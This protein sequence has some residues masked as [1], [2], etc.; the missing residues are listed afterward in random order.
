M[1]HRTLYLVFFF[2]CFS[3]ITL[4]AQDNDGD[5]ILDN[6]DLDD[7][8]DGILD[9]NDCQIAIPNFSFE[10]PGFTPPY[11]AADDWTIVGGNGTGLHNIEASN[12]PAADEGNYFF[13]MNTNPGVV[14]QATTSNL[15]GIYSEGGYILTV[16]IGDGIGATVFRNDAESI[17]ELGYYDN[18]GIFIT[19]NSRTIDGATETPAG[20]WTDFE[21][22]VNINAGDLALGQGIFI[23]ITHTGATGAQAGNYDNIRLE[24]DSDGDG[25]SNCFE[26]DS[27]GDGINDVLEAGHTDADNNGILDG[28]LNPLDGTITGIDGY[29]GN[30]D[31]V[32]DDNKDGSLILDN[33]GDAYLD[34]D[35][36]DDDNDGI[37]DNN[38]CNVIITNNS[39]ENG[40]AG[41]PITGWSNTNNVGT[42]FWGIEPIDPNNY[43]SIP[44]GNS[45]AIINGD[46]TITLNQAS[47]AF[48]IGNYITSVEI[49]DGLET[50]NPY[51]N[52]GQTLIE[53]GYDNGTGFQ[54]INDLIVE[55]Y[56]TPNGFWT[57]FT[58][59][60]SIPAGSP[61]IGE[62]ILVQITHTANALLRQQGGDYDLVQVRQDRNANG[63]PDCF[64]DD[65]DN[66]GCSDVTEA[67]HTDNG[68]GEVANIGINAD[69]TVMPAGA[70]TAYT[71]IN[72]A[73]LS[74]TI[75]ICAE[76]LDYDNDGIED[77]VDLDDDNDGIL[78]IYECEIPLPN[79]SFETD[80]LPADPIQNWQ[81]VTGTNY[82]IETINGTNFTAAQ[83]GNS[84]GFINGNGS[85][86]LNEVWA[87]YDREATYILEFSIGD[88]IPF[89]PQFS[90]DSR[91]IVELGYS[92]GTTFTAFAAGDYTVESY[93]TPNGT[94]SKFSISVPVTTATTGFGQG[95]SIR[96][97]HDDTSLNNTSQTT[98]DN[99]IL[100]IDTDGDGEPDCTDLDS[101][102]DGCFDVLEAGH[103]DTGGGVLG[104]TYDVNGLVSGAASGYTGPRHQ[105]WNNTINIACNPIDTDGDGFEDGNYYRYDAGNN[106]QTNIDEDDD[107]DGLTD[108][109]EGCMLINTG[110]LRQPADFE[111][112]FNNF[113]LSGNNTPFSIAMDYWY[114]VT[115]TG[116]IFANL[117]NADDYTYEEP[118]GSGTFITPTPNYRTDGTL[119]PDLADPD[120]QNDAYL[121]LN[122]NVTITQTGSRFV[123]EEGVY[124]FT[125]AVGD[126]LDYE[127]RYRNDGTSIITIGYDTD[128]TD[129]GLAFNALPFVLTINPE[130]TPNGTWTDFSINYEIPEGSPAI[131]QHLSI[132]IEHQNNTELNQQSGNYDHIRI[133]RNTD[134]LTGAGDFIP[135]CQDIDS[136]NDGCPDSIE[137]GY[138][139]DDKDGVL[140]SVSPTVDG[141]GLVTSEVGYT[142]FPLN[143]GVRIVSEPAVIDTGLTDPTAV[144]EGE[145]AIFIAEASRAGTNTTIV[146]E[147]YIITN[148]GT[149]YNLLTDDLTYSG[150]DTNQLT[151]SAVTTGDDGNLYAVRVMGDDNLCY[152]ESIA[153]L[154]VT[155]G[156][157]AITPVAVTTAICEG[158]D[159]EFTITGTIGDIITYSFDAGLTPLTITI[160]ATGTETITFAAATADVTMEISSIESGTCTLTL[161][162]ATS[163]T[164]TVNTVPVVD[165]TTSGICAPDRLTYDVEILLNVGTITLASEGTLTGTTVTGIT[166]GNDLDITVNNNGCIRV[167]TITAPDCS[168]PVIDNPVNPNNPS[169]CF[170][171][172][173][174]DL[175]V[176]LGT[177]GDAINWYDTSTAGTLLSSGTTYTTGETAV[178]TYTYYAE[179]TEAASGCI[180]NRVPV[181]LTINPMPVADTSL[182]I[183]ECASYTLP[184]LSAD[185]YYYTGAGATGTNLAEGSDITSTQTVYIY[186]ESGTTPNCFDENSFEVSINDTPQLTLM[187]PK[188]SADL[189]TY[190]VE[191][192]NN[193]PTAVLTTSAGTISGNTIIDIPS[194]ITSITITADNNGCI[195]TSSTFAPDCSCPT[196]D[197]ATN[198]IN[199]T[200]CEGLA[201]PNLAVSLED[202]DNTINWYTTITGGTSIATGLT[203]TPTDSAI[204]TYTYY[205]EASDS[206]TGCISDNRIAVT[207]TIEP[208]PVADTLSDVEGC[209]FYI[210]PNLNVN[211]TYYT[212]PNGTGQLLIE[213]SQINQTRTIY[214]FA[215]SPNNIDCFSESEFEVTILEEPIIDLPYE[216]SICSNANG[217]T[218]SVPIGVDLGTGYIYDW[219]PNNDTNGDGIEEAIFNVTQAG[220]YSLRVYTI[221]NNINCGGSLEYIVNVTDAL[222]PQNIEIE[223]TTEGFE[224][225]SG[226]RVR[227]IVNNDIF[228]YTSFEYS[229]D[230]PDGPYQTDNFFQNVV[231]GLHTIFVRS[232]GSCGTTLESDPFL[233]VNYPTYFSP[234]GDGTNDTWFPLGLG[235]PNLTTNVVA[236][237]YDRHGKLVHYLDLFGPGWDGTY[238]GIS[239]PE[240]DYWFVIEYTDAI[241]DNRNIQFKG[242]FSL[243]R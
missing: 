84:F 111:V 177:N 71:G 167:L 6:V 219:T 192:S 52:D 119:L 63:I 190:S 125:I 89:A 4:I 25:I 83:E 138:I 116:E 131:N 236:E 122:D 239:L 82:G 18:L 166:A 98:F 173:T 234:N 217:T 72:Q 79:F 114:D 88:P 57:D 151:I 218:T 220:E 193:I 221:G 49:G 1:Q 14:A 149:T 24:R 109:Q 210:L 59:T 135:D 228:A 144:C 102:D 223:I 148:A 242:H 145:D 156:P 48:G 130:D 187:V 104:T 2:L 126:A 105:M 42:D 194:N 178:G 238:N 29:T 64:E 47:A 117:V 68:F 215:Q 216:V 157:T 184:T 180:S 147:W 77:I 226:N 179:A 58:F 110:F 230:D 93:E 91:T 7:D 115:G 132:R 100:K 95:V 128:L 41:D 152:V 211:N 202:I 188:C 208:I 112:P 22:L 26:I 81:V 225:N 62:G 80:N 227:A 176:D 153:T 212:G 168:C 181:T 56:E 129:G 70:G 87:T 155:A 134:G 21:L 224:L 182:D 171:T 86:Q 141:N 113:L 74:N 165:P 186:S 175:S 67:G 27:D 205:A 214:I 203:F 61:A 13:Y 120:Y 5:L 55:G 241:D 207:L 39:F 75:N 38:E 243:I 160:G 45:I 200:I 92:N 197:D 96:I 183:N 137:N 198:P 233:I 118:A 229:L 199:A 222:L 51:S 46:A 50:D 240:S 8:N 32:V 139:D 90:N 158:E 143:S 237:I 163:A 121:S 170:G 142:T 123:L 9:V 196:I 33:D 201:N 97:T 12:Y 107:N 40:G 44:D 103:T 164:V 209:E 78:D 23:R 169:I 140:G 162:P 174:P 99:F 146:Y 133:Q 65:I 10:A 3:T 101:D 16:A 161:T 35:D 28:I 43:Y 66:D 54:A 154:N 206:I 108:E 94:W 73:V 136:D 85:I 195:A 232:A 106:L 172:A 31:D 191:F 204:G 185:N 213:G 53:I 19:V 189:N 124:M 17:I 11:P 36:L 60:T 127:N 150:T 30:R 76:N 235:D 15:L 20:E 231:G 159:A 37:L 34:K 69:G